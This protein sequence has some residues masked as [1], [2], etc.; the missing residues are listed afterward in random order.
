[1]KAPAFW[2]DRQA[3]AGRLLEPFGWLYGAAT[4]W[5]LAHA[6]PWRAPIPVICVGNLTAGGTGKTPIVRDLS[7]RLL[8]KG[9]RPHILSRGHGG[10]AKGPIQVDRERHGAADVGDEPL[11][12]ARDAPCWIAADRAAGARAIVAAGGDV[13]L[14]DDGLQNP[15]LAQNLKIL[16][17]DGETGFGNG[18]LLPAG[19]L[20]EAISEGL[21]RADAIVVMGEDRANIVSA[22]S[23]STPIF[24][25]A[26]ESPLAGEL[27]GRKLM[28]FAGIGRP[29]KFRLTL[30]DTG[31][32]VVAFRAFADHKPYTE[33]V[34]EGLIA[35][36]AKAGAALVTTE[37]DWI[38]LPAAWRERIR[39]IPVAVRWRDESAINCLIAQ[40]TARG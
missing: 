5:R 26:L 7:A 11:L 13:V 32:D 3:P 14:M 18:R 21:A 8:A 24:Q 2:Q 33:R 15:T 25:A 12:L 29:E 31:A 30:A 20:R 9:R 22:I 34:L 36:A 16:V 4:R 39:A 17:V 19:P 6:H 35:E 23:G 28:G 27:A 40:A 37:K 10:S 1:M 38:R